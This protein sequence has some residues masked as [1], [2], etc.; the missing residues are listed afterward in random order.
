MACVMPSCQ[1]GAG[2]IILLALKFLMEDLVQLR[3]F[4]KGKD[5]VLILGPM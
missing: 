2:F 1:T 3:F 5:A 4:K